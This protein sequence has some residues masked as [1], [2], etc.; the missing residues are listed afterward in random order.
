MFGFFK[1]WYAKEELNRDQFF[2]VD[3]AK[4]SKINH[5]E[6]LRITLD[7]TNLGH[8]ALDVH[9]VKPSTVLINDEAYLGE[10]QTAS[11]SIAPQ[12]RRQIHMHFNLPLREKSKK[13]L[14]VKVETLEINAA[15]GG[16]ER[17]IQRGDLTHYNR[18]CLIPGFS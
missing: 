13:A 9:S 18:A 8:M 15:K 16:N 11:Y 14:N 6:Q 17:K 10:L 3:I 7:C 2:R 1:K 12:Q 4:I 5:G